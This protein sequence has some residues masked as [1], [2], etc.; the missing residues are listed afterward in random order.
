MFWQKNIFAICKQLRFLVPISFCWCHKKGGVLVLIWTVLHILSL[1]KSRVLLFFNSLSRILNQIMTWDRLVSLKKS[2]QKST[3][4]LTKSMVWPFNRSCH[5]SPTGKVLIYWAFMTSKRRDLW[6]T[7]PGFYCLPSTSTYWIKHFV[8][9]FRV[10][11]KWTSITMTTW[12]N[13]HGSLCN[14]SLFFRTMNIS[15]SLVPSWRWVVRSYFPLNVIGW[16]NALKKQ[17]TW[18]YYVQHAKMVEWI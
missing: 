12:I 8:C 11:K 16:W 3:R 9:C 17:G 4:F 1:L 5:A 2:S 13:S 15:T 14:A 7:F 6:L 18:Y 10:K